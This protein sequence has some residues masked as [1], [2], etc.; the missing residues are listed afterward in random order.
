MMIVLNK[1]KE[2]QFIRIVWD[3]YPNSDDTQIMVLYDRYSKKEYTVD[4]GFNNSNSTYRYG[5][6]IINKEDIE[7]LLEGDYLYRIYN[8]S[9]INMCEV[10]S[11][12]SRGILR[13]ELSLSDDKV[14]E[15]QP[16][17]LDSEESSGFIVFDDSN[18]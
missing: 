4:L 6:Y 16:I 14:V 8:Q 10:L 1:S 2:S 12:L 5:R 13:V 7:E 18:L 17:V 3:F 15:R 9:N 11:P